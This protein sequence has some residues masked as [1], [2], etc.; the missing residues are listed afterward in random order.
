MAGLA[1]AAEY[2]SSIK[3]SVAFVAIYGTQ[4]HISKPNTTLINPI[5][6]IEIDSP[7]LGS[8]RAFALL[9][10]LSLD[11]RAWNHHEVLF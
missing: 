4:L 8:L 9:L 3:S 5:L 10:S 6:L 2:S 11:K 1:L 7:I